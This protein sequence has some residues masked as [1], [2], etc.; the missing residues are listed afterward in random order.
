MIYAAIFA[1]VGYH[2]FCDAIPNGEIPL[3]II[4]ITAYVIGIICGEIVEN[5]L[6][7]RIEKLEKELR[8]E[9]EI[10]ENTL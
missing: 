3:V 8:K 10:N 7:K 5:R 2:T 1:A 9:S 6:K 4:G